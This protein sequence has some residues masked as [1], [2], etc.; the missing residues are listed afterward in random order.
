M[1]PVLPHPR[2]EQRDEVLCPVVTIAVLGLVVGGGM[3]F[4]LGWL[5]CGLTED[6]ATQTGWAH[7]SFAAGWG[8]VWGLALAAAATIAAYG[9]AV[10]DADLPRRGRSAHRSP[11][12]LHD[13]DFRPM[14]APPPLRSGLAAHISA[15]PSPGA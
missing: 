13:E 3:G 7:L 14:P 10:L 4:V 1:I 9:A 5:L 11:P 6:G 12:F 15:P 2:P 8:L